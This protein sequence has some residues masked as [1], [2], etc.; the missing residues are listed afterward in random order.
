MPVTKKPASRSGQTGSSG[1]VASNLKRAQE[2]FK[3]REL[4]ITSV[5][6]AI[7]KDKEKKQKEDVPEEVPKQ[8]LVP[9]PVSPVPTIAYSPPHPRRCDFV[10]LACCI[11]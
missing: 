4:L 3:K 11:Q 9:V 8:E 6:P 10:C 2:R 7:L 5:I 1:W